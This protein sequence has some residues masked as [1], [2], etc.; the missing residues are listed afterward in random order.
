MKEGLN[1][2]HEKSENIGHLSYNPEY[3]N[4]V[5]RD[6]DG[7][8]VRDL[9]SRSMVE[10]RL[11]ST[12]LNEP[13]DWVDAIVDIHDEIGDGVCWNG[14]YLEE[15]RTGFKH[16]LVSMSKYDNSIEVNLG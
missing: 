11:P 5:V 2:E 4:W 15:V 10:V 13:N 12:S 1:M 3:K 6:A 9:S 7:K 8:E 16:F 14:W